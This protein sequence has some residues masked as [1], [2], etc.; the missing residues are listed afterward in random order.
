MA[1]RA[2][3]RSSY[4][5]KPRHCSPAR[6]LACDLFEVRKVTDETDPAEPRAHTNMPHDQAG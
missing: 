1:A 5:A 3:T 2:V 6:L 4:A